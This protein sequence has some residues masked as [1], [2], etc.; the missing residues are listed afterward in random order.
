MFRILIG[1]Q[2]KRLLSGFRPVTTQKNVIIY[3]SSGP[4]AFT[5]LISPQLSL[6]AYKHLAATT[7]S[8]TFGRKDAASKKRRKF[9][10]RVV[11]ASNAVPSNES[12]SKKTRLAGLVVAREQNGIEVLPAGGGP[13][14]PRGRLS[15]CLGLI[16]RGL[17]RPGKHV[18]RSMLAGSP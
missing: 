2:R 5:A 7:S 15:L 6:I 14:L 17:R 16:A 18:I 8:R 4:V 9:F 13:Q 3:L 11:V 12:R 1:S 10:F